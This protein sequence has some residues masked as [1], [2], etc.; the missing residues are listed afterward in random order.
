MPQSEAEELIELIELQG[1]KVSRG[2]FIKKNGEESKFHLIP[3]SSYKLMK[4]A[5]RARE[6][7]LAHG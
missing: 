7:E 5:M 1:F 6:M 3:I 2:S 4:L